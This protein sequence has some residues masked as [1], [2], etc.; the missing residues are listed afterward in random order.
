MNPHSAKGFALL[1]C[2]QPRS[3]WLSYSLPLLIITTATVRNGLGPKVGSTCSPI[4]LPVLLPRPTLPWPPW[5]YFL[6]LVPS[7][8][9]HSVI[10]TRTKKTEDAW[11]RALS[12]VVWTSA[13]GPGL[14]RAKIGN[15]NDSS[16]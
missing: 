2:R 8:E 9:F 11:D 14:T 5:L 16:G 13:M 6:L 4:S 1:Q 7:A 12:G 10:N 3:G 15:F